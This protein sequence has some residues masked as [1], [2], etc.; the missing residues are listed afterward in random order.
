MI[1]S[2]KPEN[3]DS[4]DNGDKSTG[5]EQAALRQSGRKQVLVVQRMSSASVDSLVVEKQEASQL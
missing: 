1:T 2:S 5:T 4:M 3:Q